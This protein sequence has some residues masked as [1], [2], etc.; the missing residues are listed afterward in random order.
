MVVTAARCIH[1]TPDPVGA[2]PACRPCPSD[3]LPHGSTRR[4]RLEPPARLL[5]SLRPRPAHHA[6]HRYRYTHPPAADPANPR[7]F[8]PSG[9]EA[10]RST[11]QPTRGPA[12]RPAARGD[13]VEPHPDAIWRLPS[14]W[15]IAFSSIAV[16]GPDYR[17]AISAH[18]HT[19]MM[20]FRQGECGSRRSSFYARIDA[21]V[22]SPRCAKPRCNRTSAVARSALPYHELCALGRQVAPLT[23]MPC[24]A[25]LATALLVRFAS[26]HAPD[27]IH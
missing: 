23:L 5:V 3:H 12:G 14:S 8:S 9:C 17:R 18:S 16:R 2:D 4:T 19:L 26:L 1:F 6:F 20:P 15:P 22:L 10:F 27:P 11:C 25:I 7:H 21:V 13:A 24:Y